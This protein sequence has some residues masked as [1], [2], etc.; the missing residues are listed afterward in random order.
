MSVR[1]LVSLLTAILLPCANT[2]AFDCARTET[3]LNLGPSNGIAVAGEIAVIGAGGTIVAFDLSVPTAPVRHGELRLA[4]ETDHDLGVRPLTAFGQLVLVAVN[5][6][7]GPRLAVIDPSAVGGPLEIASLPVAHPAEEAVV[8]ADHAWLVEGGADGGSLIGIDLSDP[9]HPAA[10]ATMVFS[11]PAR[12]L[13]A[14][15]G[16]VVLTT[17]SGLHVIDVAHPSNPASIG[18]LAISGSVA[19]AASSDRAYVA[20]DQLTIHVVDLTT[21]QSP[22][23]TAAL[24][25]PHIA[26]PGQMTVLGDRLY[27]GMVDFDPSVALP[28]GGLA[29]IDVRDATAP[30]ELGFATFSSGAARLAV[31]GDHVVAADWERGLRVFEATPAGVPAEIARRNVTRDD[32]FS[33]A[34]RGDLAFVGDQG[35]RVVD[36]GDHSQPRELAVVELDGEIGA[37][38]AGTGSDLVLALSSNHRIAVVDAATPTAPV[39]RGFIDT[40]SDPVD[41]AAAGGYAVIADRVDG[42]LVFDLADP[43]HPVELARAATSGAPRAVALAGS[44]ALVG[45]SQPG[46][47]GALAVF[48]L[49]L[50]SAP[51]LLSQLALPM[52]ADKVATSSQLAMVSAW[53]TVHV[54]D[55][56]DPT[57][58][59]ELAS[60]GTSTVTGIAFVGDLAYVSHM[61][62]SLQ[63]LDVSEPDH[64]FITGSAVWVPFTIVDGGPVGGY[65]IATHDGA[66]VI[67]DGRYGLRLVSIDRCLTDPAIP[68]TAVAVDE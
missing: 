7:E 65:G 20:T 40:A 9:W 28:D 56:S 12:S 2:P 30:S 8:V 17:G 47:A 16:L 54:I 4:E 33:V 52:P 3:T 61:P 42:L 45:L 44:L 68:S 19:V 24:D 57:A 38:A 32:A 29:V 11:S 10:A 39:L 46:N 25:L 64:P 62:G 6:D 53:N 41:V 27:V 43:G 26:W 36:L 66:A 21:P 13:A 37:V 15:A 63:V 59:V 5:G 51:S 35:L 60:D 67:A 34:V 58:P 18:W 22:A 14:S 31:A 50:A 48:D 1:L 49:S 23:E 55:L